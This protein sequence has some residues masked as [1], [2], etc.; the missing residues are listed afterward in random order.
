MTDVGK[1]LDVN[2]LVEKGKQYHEQHNYKEMRNCFLMAINKGSVEAMYQIGFYY[3]MS[4]DF[5]NM[6]KYYK[7]ASEYG[8]A[9]AMNALAC[10]YD[11]RN[12]YA[13]MMKYFNLA[14]EH[15]NPFAMIN[16]GTYHRKHDNIPEAKKYYLM[17]LRTSPKVYKYIT[18]VS[19]IFSDIELYYILDN[20]TERTDDMNKMMDNLLEKHNVFC[21]RNKIRILGKENECPICLETKMS[22]P[23]ECAHYVCTYCFTQIKSCPQCSISHHYATNVITIPS[24]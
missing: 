13:N 2:E 15:K 17:A 14:I 10:H 19:Q 20:L 6:E 22:V 11:V 1:S 8:H 18:S 4:L 3:E 24:Q 5:Y 21:Y 12:D 16:F 23:M 7:M 9:D